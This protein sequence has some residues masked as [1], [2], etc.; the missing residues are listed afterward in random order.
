MQGW[1]G[2]CCK[3]L[4]SGPHGWKGV[5]GPKGTSFAI[6][7]D[8][9]EGWQGIQQDIT[10]LVEPNETYVIRAVVRTAGQPHEGANVLASVRLENA[11]SN[12][13]YVNVG[14]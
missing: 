10:D 7:L 9:K 14:R 4:H 6:A 2:I 3:I 11:G 1:S 8:R 12:T 13:R 5:S